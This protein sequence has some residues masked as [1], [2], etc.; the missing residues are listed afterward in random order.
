VASAHGR[1]SSGR[2]FEDDAESSLSKRGLMQR[3]M[4]LMKL[5]LKNEKNANEVI[6]QKIG[7]IGRDMHTGNYAMRKLEEKA[8][9]RQ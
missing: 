9:K 8:G 7:E 4:Y 1:T 3:K 5:M 2:L 6:K